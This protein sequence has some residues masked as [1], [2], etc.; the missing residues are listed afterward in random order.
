MPIMN[1][2]IGEGLGTYKLA[3]GAGVSIASSGTATVTT[4][5]STIVGF[6]VTPEAAISLSAT[7]SGGTITVSN[8]TASAGSFT[9]IAIGF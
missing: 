8:A 1:L 5:L 9:W 4:G 2:P 3:T 7:V 6:G